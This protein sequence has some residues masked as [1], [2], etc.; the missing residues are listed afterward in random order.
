M[1]K[2]KGRKR[3]PITPAREAEIIHLIEAWD[4]TANP[5]NRE[6]LTRAVECRLG[7]TVTRQG[8][9]KRDAIRNAFEDRQKEILLGQPLKPAKDPLEDRYER[10]VKQLI[11]EFDQAKATIE[12]FKEL[13]ARYRYNANQHGLS[14]ERL[15]APIP[16]RA[17]SEGARG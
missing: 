2:Q 14:R 7:F 3:E 13:F 16:P 5:F 9:M 6:A 17:T 1:I 8:L 11:D 4:A 15:E 10:R 12:N